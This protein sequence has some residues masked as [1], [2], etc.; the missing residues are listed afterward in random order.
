MFSKRKTRH[1]RQGSFTASSLLASLL[2]LLTLPFISEAQT[3]DA[4]LPICCQTHG[5]HQCSIRQHRA[6]TEQQGTG[7]SALTVHEKCPFTPAAPVGTHTDS[8]AL[9][10]PSP[11]AMAFQES[12]ATVASRHFVPQHNLEA[13]NPKRGPPSTTIL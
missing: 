3:P 10:A 9:T 7:A 1:G 5:K 11:R 6:A 4:T 13:S 8:T 12:A 2:L